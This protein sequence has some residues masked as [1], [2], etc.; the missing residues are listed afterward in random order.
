M[1]NATSPAGDLKSNVQSQ[2]VAAMK[3]GDKPRTQ[4]LRMLLS[5]IKAKEADDPKAVAQAAVTGYANKLKKAL[6]DMEKLGQAEHAAQLRADMA[7]VEEFLPR[8]MDDAALEKLVAETLAPLGSLTKKD[9]G[10]AIGAVMKAV[11]AAGAS[12]DAGKVRALVESKL[13]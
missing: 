11:A 6:A 4:V 1:A 8:Q 3:A 2:M 12:A 13:I 7:I 9:S 5:E 10:R